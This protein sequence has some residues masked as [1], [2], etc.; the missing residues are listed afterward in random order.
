MIDAVHE[1]EWLVFLFRVNV[2]F[3]I[4]LTYLYSY[5]LAVWW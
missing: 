3:A 5:I 4:N 1:H 2:Q